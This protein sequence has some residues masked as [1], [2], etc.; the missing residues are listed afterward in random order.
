MCGLPGH[1]PGDLIDL[2]FEGETVS[3]IFDAGMS[4][5]LRLSAEEA[6]ALVVALRTLAETPGIAD[7]DAVQ[8]ALAKVES[9]AGGSVDD[10][11]VTVALDATDQAAAGAASRGERVARAGAALLHGRP[12]RVDRTHRRPAAGLRGRRARL[13]RGVVPQ[14][15]GRAGV[16]R[17]P[18]RGRRAAR[19]AGPAAAGHRAARP[20]RRRVP[21]VDR[22]PAGRAAGVDGVRLGRRL[23]PRRRGHRVPDGLQVSFRV[24]EPAWCARWC[25]ARAARSRC[26][27]RAGWPSRSAPTRLARS[28]PTRVLERR[29]NHGR[30]SAGRPNE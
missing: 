20:R 27:R 7:S 6:L 15:R 18:H 28:R 12:R 23:L 21:A 4:R 25:S 29:A 8:R 9:A 17:R 24:A 19:R 11:T 30:C 13:S 16:P 2:S 5:P 1:G 14:R 10:A 26:S 22:A 3:V